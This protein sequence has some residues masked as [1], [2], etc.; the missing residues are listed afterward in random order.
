MADAS[1]IFGFLKALAENN[2]RPWFEA[3]KSDYLK[4]KAEAEMLIDDCIKEL[5]R[6]IPLPELKSKQCMFRIYR[7]VRFSKN[8]DPF[9][10]NFSALISAAGKKAG[11]EPSW[12]LHLEPGGSFMASGVYEPSAE[13]LAAIRQE[14]EYN[15][16]EF[17]AILAEPELKKRFGLLQGNQLKTAP[18]NYSR[19]HPDIDLLRY[20]QFYLM[21]EY[22]DAELADAAFPERFTKD[23][24]LLKDFQA[25]LKRASD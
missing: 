18:K 11:L 17:R 1:L 15:A 21:A 25:F 5:G 9:K 13:Q 16:E 10:K 2:N 4:A 19:E 12:Y 22:S 23:C 24:L 7:D 20:T 3:S 14:I 8:K 6:N